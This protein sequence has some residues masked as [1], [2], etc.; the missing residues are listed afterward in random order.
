M[1]QQL[2][3]LQMTLKTEPLEFEWL[4]NGWD[5]IIYLFIRLFIEVGFLSSSI[6]IY[7]FNR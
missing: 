6:P 7:S 5:Y 2:L 1:I 4:V 3:L